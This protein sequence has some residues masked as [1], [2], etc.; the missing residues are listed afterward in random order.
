MSVDIT[1]LILKNV[2]YFFLNIQ[3]KN[4]KIGAKLEWQKIFSVDIEL[5]Q[6]SS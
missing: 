6:H 5:Q 1:V 3:H 2:L 4:Y